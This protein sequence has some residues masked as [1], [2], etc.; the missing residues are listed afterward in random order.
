MSPI[1]SQ[2]LGA[3]LADTAAA[4]AV[5]GPTNQQILAA[6]KAAYQAHQSAVD[7]LTTAL[8]TD[9]ADANLANARNALDAIDWAAPGVTPALV[10][11][12]LEGAAV[13]KALQTVQADPA[14]VAVSV[15]A[16]AATGPAGGPEVPGFVAPLPLSDTRSGLVVELDIFRHLVSVTAGQNLQYGVW[17]TAAPASDTVVGLYVN[18]QATTSVNLKILLD[19]NLQPVGFVSSTGATVPLTTGVFAGSVRPWTF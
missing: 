8:L 17:L 9:V 10:A 11:P 13:T 16:F 12:F 3:E 6:A 14:C 15:G 7:A 19:G 2:V 18:V 1:A 4:A 5:T